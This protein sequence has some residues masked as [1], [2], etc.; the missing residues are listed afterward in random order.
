MKNSD[1]FILQGRRVYFL[2]LIL[3]LM[4]VQ[5]ISKPQTGSSKK[6]WQVKT[7][8]GVYFKYLRVSLVF[9]ENTR[10]GFHLLEMLI[11]FSRDKY[12]FYRN[13]SMIYFGMITAEQRV[14]ILT[15]S[16]HKFTLWMRHLL[17]HKYQMKKK[18]SLNKD[19]MH[20]TISHRHSKCYTVLQSIIS[21]NIIKLLY[22]LHTLDVPVLQ[23]S[24]K[25]S[26]QIPILE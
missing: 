20:C 1:L 14:N 8:I 11:F 24:F 16:Y 6:N 19:D 22:S 5:E 2:F 25:R 13:W 21:Y 9:T 15:F 17:P 23:L 26:T 18:P 10:I 12:K 3:V 7:V 4:K